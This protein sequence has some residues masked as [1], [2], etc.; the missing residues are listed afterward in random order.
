MSSYPPGY[1]EPTEEE[2]EYWA[3]KCRLRDLMVEPVQCK[4]CN[5]WG[6][7]QESGK[8]DHCNSMA[9]NRCTYEYDGVY[10]CIDCWEKRDDNE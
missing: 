4:Y 8:C 10:F 6:E 5:E 7:L 9:C 2:T 3:E 1:K